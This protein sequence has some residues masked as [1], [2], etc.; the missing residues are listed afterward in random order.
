VVFAPA[1]HKPYFHIEYWTLIAL[2]DALPENW[3][4]KTNC[5]PKEREKRKTLTRRRWP[6]Q[7]LFV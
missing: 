1:T 5:D 7:V 3:N 2:G 4:N 6:K